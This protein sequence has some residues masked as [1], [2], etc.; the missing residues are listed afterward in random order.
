LSPSLLRKEGAIHRYAEHYESIL[1]SKSIFIF[2]FIVLISETKNPLT[3][4]YFIIISETLSCELPS[5]R[6]REGMGVSIYDTKEVT[7]PKV[8]YKDLPP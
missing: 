1:R 4:Y 7:N 5:L 2:H 8:V 6:S 3:H